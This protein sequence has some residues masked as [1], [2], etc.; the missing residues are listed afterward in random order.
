MTLLQAFFPALQEAGLGSL[1]Y[2]FK[3]LEKNCVFNF[4]KKILK[5]LKK[6]KN[7]VYGHFNQWLKLT[8]WPLPN[9]P[10]IP[11]I[12][13]AACDSIR[14]SAE[15]RW[16]GENDKGERDIFASVSLVRILIV[17][18]IFPVFY[19]IFIQL[20]KFNN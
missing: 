8:G 20:H 5:L 12:F 9:H 17:T 18:E 10:T 11:N 15:V 6:L 4:L 3:N 16:L 19:N 2:D 14:K 13:F 7:K 1:I